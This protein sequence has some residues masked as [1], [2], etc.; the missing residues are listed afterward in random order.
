[1]SMCNQRNYT[2]TK[3]ACSGNNLI[4]KYFYTQFVYS[5][6]I[7]SRIFNTNSNLLYK[8]VSKITNKYYT[9][10]EISLY[11]TFHR[12]QIKTIYR[13]KMY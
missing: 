4:Q 5:I 1:M 11:F 8:I 13:V 12:N 9:E 10:K 6:R 2:T 7:S 3:N